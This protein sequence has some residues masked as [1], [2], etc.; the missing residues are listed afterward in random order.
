MLVY[1]KII[2]DRYYCIKS[3]VACKLWKHVPKS[4]IFVLPIMSRTNLE[5]LYV[6]KRHVSEQKVA[7]IL[8]S[9]NYVHFYARYCW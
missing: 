4:S 7:S 9:F 5:D 1:Q 8:T 2:F 6:L 3:F